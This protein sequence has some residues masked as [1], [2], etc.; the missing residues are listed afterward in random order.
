MEVEVG[1]RA[2]VLTKDKGDEG[3]EAK[4]THDK[5]VHQFLVGQISQMRLNYIENGIGNEKVGQERLDGTLG[6]LR[7]GNDDRGKRGEHDENTKNW[8]PREKQ[9]IRVEFR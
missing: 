1:R 8:P 9:R 5:E 7:P 6:Q 3:K 2:R 4:E